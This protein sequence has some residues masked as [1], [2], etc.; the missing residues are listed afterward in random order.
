[1]LSIQKSEKH[2]F[3]LLLS[4]WF[5][6]EHLTTL[7]LDSGPQILNLL[8]L[9]FWSQS[10]NIESNKKRVNKKLYGEYDFWF[11]NYLEGLKNTVYKSLPSQ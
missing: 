5:F 6:E 8:F 9:L 7:Q 1:M 3:Q 4:T 2:G 10:S 11:L